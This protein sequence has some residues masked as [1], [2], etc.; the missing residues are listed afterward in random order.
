ML[1]FSLIM[2]IIGALITFEDFA[3]LEKLLIIGA[4]LILLFLFIC[5]EIRKKI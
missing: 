3:K 4:G 5:I 1:S 2:A